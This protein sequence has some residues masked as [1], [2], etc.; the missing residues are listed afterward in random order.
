MLF[1]LI[2]IHRNLDETVDMGDEERSTRSAKYEL[3]I[4]HKTGKTKYTIGSI[5][6]TA[7]FSGLLLP[8]Q[9]E[10]PIAYHL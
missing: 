10:R 8:Q 9:T 1:K 6:L 2:L 7:L 3:P 5:Y 4:Y